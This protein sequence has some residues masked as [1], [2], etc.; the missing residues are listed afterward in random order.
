VPS[1]SNIVGDALEE[2]ARKLLGGRRVKGSGSGKFW[3]LDVTDKLRFIY[4]CKATTK[5]YI[6]VTKEMLREAELAAHGARGTGDRYK[7][8]MVIEVDGEAYVITRLEDQSELMT[9][10]PETRPLP[11][12]KGRERLARAL[13]SPRDR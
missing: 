11:A 9:M 12:G 13:A 10:P 2:R 5:P 1:V 3:K 8:A 4:S 6:R 7:P